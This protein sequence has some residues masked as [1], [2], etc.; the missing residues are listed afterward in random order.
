[1]GEYTG[2]YSNRAPV[3]VVRINTGESSLPINHGHRFDDYLDCEVC[4][5]KWDRD[6]LPV[7][8]FG[9]TSGRV[10]Q[11]RKDEAKNTR[12]QEGQMKG[13]TFEMQPVRNTW[14]EHRNRNWYSDD[15][16]LGVDHED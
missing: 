8:E 5:I 11:A 15:W 10:R 16:D 12:E 13:F 1:M 7:C 2:N 14:S 3:D 4:Q 9:D 6:Y